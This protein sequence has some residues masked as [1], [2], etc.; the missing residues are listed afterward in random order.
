MRGITRHLHPSLAPY[1]GMKTRNDPAAWVFR[2]NTFSGPQSLGEEKTSYNPLIP[3]RP[4]IPSPTT[5]K[6]LTPGVVIYLDF[7]GLFP[8]HDYPISILV[9]SKL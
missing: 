8:S 5:P 3:V 6:P 7:T 1:R 2:F 4:S 9:T